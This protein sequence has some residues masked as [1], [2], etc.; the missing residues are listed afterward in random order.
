[1]DMGSFQVQAILNSAAMNTGCMYF[2]ELWF[3]LDIC[4]AVGL[5]GHMVVSVL[6]S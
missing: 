1:M 4:P 5:L 6:V 3:S 2:F